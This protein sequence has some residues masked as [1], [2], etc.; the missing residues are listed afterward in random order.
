[1]RFQRRLNI[2]RYLFIAS[3]VIT[4]H[5][6]EPTFEDPNRFSNRGG[7]VYI[8]YIVYVGVSV[9][10]GVMRNAA[11]SALSASS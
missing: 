1:M 10:V 4:A 11:L 9:C 5:W 8:V 3:E 6:G 2:W 7:I